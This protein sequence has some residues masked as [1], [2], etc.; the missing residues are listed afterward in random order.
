[1]FVHCVFLIEIRCEANLTIKNARIVY[2]GM[3]PNDMALVVCLF[4]YKVNFDQVYFT[5][6]EGK[7]LPSENLKVEC[8]RNSFFFF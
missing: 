3:R 8:Q 6:E 7:W 1:M 5:C 4:G 2:T